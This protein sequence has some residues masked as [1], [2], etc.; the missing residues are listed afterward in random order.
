[1]QTH[2]LK[3]NHIHSI[4]MMAVSVC[5]LLSVAMTAVVMATERRV[6]GT[7][8]RCGDS[9]LLGFIASVR[10]SRMMVTLAR[11]TATT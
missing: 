2:L 11:R 4:F 10:S 5:W 3:L 8:I 1:M 7:L 9:R 6:C